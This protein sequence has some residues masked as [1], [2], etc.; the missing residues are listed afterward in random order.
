MGDIKLD[1]DGDIFI[2]DDD[3][4]L[5]EG[6]DAIAQDV[7][8]RLTFFLGEWFLDTRLGVP[9]FEKILGQKPVRVEVVKS[10]LRKAIMTT[11]GMKG[12]ADFTVDFDG[13]TRKLSVSF[14]GETVEGEFE[15][16]RELII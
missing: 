12:I 13:L 5:V 16:D 10:I 6:V 4:V 8:I 7:E 15:F 14:R 1:P 2:E 3:L 11:P 9:Y